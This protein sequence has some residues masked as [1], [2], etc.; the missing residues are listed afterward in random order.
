MLGK[1]PFRCQNAFL[2]EALFFGRIVILVILIYALLKKRVAVG[3]IHVLFYF[4]L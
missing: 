4:T 1:L 2:I 3:V